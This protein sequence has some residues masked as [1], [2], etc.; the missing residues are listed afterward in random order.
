MVRISDFLRN[1][2]YKKQNDSKEN[3]KNERKS[4][5]DR[6]RELNR[7]MI[8]EYEKGDL[9]NAAFTAERIK[10]IAESENV[11]PIYINWRLVEGLSRIL[12]KSKIVGLY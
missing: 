11:S 6:L 3:V 10:I 5:E 8:K 7:K 9:Y 12:E 4:V 1:A 2:R